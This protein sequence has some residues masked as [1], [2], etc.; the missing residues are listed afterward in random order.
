MSASQLQIK[1]LVSY[2]RCRIYREFLQS[3]IAA[4]GVRTSG[5]PGLFCFSG[6]CSYTNFCTP[7]LSLPKTWISVRPLAVLVSCIKL[8]HGIKISS[9]F[10]NAQIKKLNYNWTVCWRFKRIML[11]YIC[12]RKYNNHCGPVSREG[13]VRNAIKAGDSTVFEPYG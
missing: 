2:S 13:R 4:R 11:N 6:F 3:L 9:S 10:S 7:Y 8:A 12:I 5:R 1:Q